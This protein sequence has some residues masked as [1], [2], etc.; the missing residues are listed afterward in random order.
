MVATTIH[1]AVYDGKVLAAGTN[2]YSL[3][4]CLRKT[5]EHQGALWPPL[6]DITIYAVPNASFYSM[7][8]LPVRRIVAPG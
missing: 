6:A 5:K 8:G 4:K 2:A 1:V 3:R 7:T